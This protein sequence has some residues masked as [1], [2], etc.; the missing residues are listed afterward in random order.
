MSV[1]TWGRGDTRRLSTRDFPAE[2]LALVDEAQQGRYC[3]ACREAELAT[4]ADEPLELDHKRALA[5]GGDNNYR[6]LQWLCQGHNRSKGA[7]KKAATL[8]P[9]AKRAPR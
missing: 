9:W 8:P 6:N 7:R 1:Y 5:R 2:V 3:V 4:P